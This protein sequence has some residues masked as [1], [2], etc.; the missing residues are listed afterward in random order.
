MSKQI[1]IEKNVLASR[2][3]IRGRGWLLWRV[4]LSLVVR[5]ISGRRKAWDKVGFRCIST[6]DFVERILWS[7]SLRKNNRHFA[8]PLLIS[9]R[10]ERRNFILM[11]RHYPDLSSVTC[12]QN[13]ISALVCQTPFCGETSGV[14]VKC[15]LLTQVNGVIVQ[16]KAT[17]AVLLHGT[18]F[19][20]FWFQ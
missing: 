20:V 6:Y 18:T 2:C 12:H 7:D 9:P 16:I 4:P 3:S 17:S 15:R 5:A 8:M 14:V 10:N 19:S 13:K 1:T 11:T